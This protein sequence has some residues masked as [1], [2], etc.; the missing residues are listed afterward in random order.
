MIQEVRIKAGLD[1]LRVLCPIEEEVEVEVEEVGIKKYLETTKVKIR[2]EDQIN[3][4]D[5]L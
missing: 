1:Q 2:K 3:D 4:V 5:L